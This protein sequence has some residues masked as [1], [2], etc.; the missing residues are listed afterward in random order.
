[1]RDAPIEHVDAARDGKRMHEVHQ[2]RERVDSIGWKVCPCTVS[3][4]R[5]NSGTAITEAIAVSLMVTD[6]SEAERRQHPH[7]RLAAA[8]CGGTICARDMPSASAARVCPA[9]TDSIPARKISAAYA[10]EV[11]SSVPAARPERRHRDAGDD[12]QR[13]ECPDQNDQHGIARIESM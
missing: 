10:A 5:M 1:M 6:R 8:R 3:D 2:H 12:R 9:R 13:E 11:E 4:C 7:D